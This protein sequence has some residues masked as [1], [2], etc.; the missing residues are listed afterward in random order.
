MLATTS[1]SQH[2]SHTPRSPTSEISKSHFFTKSKVFLFKTKVRWKQNKE[3]MCCFEQI[4]FAESEKTAVIRPLSSYLANYP[5]KANK[6]CWAL[7]EKQCQTL[8]HGYTNI[9]QPAKKL[10]SSIFF[11]Q[12]VTSRGST[13]NNFNKDWRWKRVKGIYPLSTSW[14]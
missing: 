10:H 12:W 3:A 13:K 4:L 6:T 5:K 9:G 14:W 1:R 7:L 8:S 11:G 2:V